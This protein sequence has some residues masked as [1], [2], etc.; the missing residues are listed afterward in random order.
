MIARLGLAI[1]S[2]RVS[3]V[4][5][6][7]GVAAWSEVRSLE[8]TM[9]RADVIA[10]V[11]GACPR[12]RFFP[13]RVIVAIGPSAVQVKQLHDVPLNVDH[14]ALGA[15]V[16]EGAGRFF[17]KN[18]KPLETT[19]AP[20]GPDG[21][22][23]AAAYDSSLISE[24]EQGCRKARWRLAAVVPVVTVLRLATRDESIAWADGELRFW[25]AYDDAKLTRVRYGHDESVDAPA[26]PAPSPAVIG[27]GIEKTTLLPAF[28]ATQIRPDEPLALRRFHAFATAPTKRQLR[29]AALSS[30]L[31]LGSWWL[32][33]GV[34]A[35]VHA[36]RAEQNLSR[37]AARVGVDRRELS[38]LDSV[39]SEL[40]EVAGFQART[41]SMTLLL[42]EL[43]R[44][45]PDS[46]AIDQLQVIDSTGGNI[47]A[48]APRAA[49]IVDALERVPV[50]EAPTIAGPVAGQTLGGR[51]VERVSVS[52]RFGPR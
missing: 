38:A 29:I 28:A 13:H 12:P 40:R 33:P 8:G 2:D 19:C 4:L 45:L 6:R 16:R 20:T 43:T 37:L 46:C 50:I 14:R 47:V 35:T 31:A 5:V 42:A 15:I 1:S 48:M 22:V 32:A 24:I 11:I 36:H 3:A 7:R 41:R 34:A 27:A 23:W 52:F 21:T 9:S 39:T 25:A 51:S 49:G 18:G 44:A 17:L 30:V 10:Q 26:V